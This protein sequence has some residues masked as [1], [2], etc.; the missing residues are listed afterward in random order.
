MPLKRLAALERKKLQEEY[1]ELVQRIAW[2]EDLLAH[3]EKVLG[4]IKEELLALKQQYNDPR[5]TQIVELG[6]SRASLTVQDM[7]ADEPVMVAL[8]ATAC[9]FHPK[10]WSNGGASCPTRWGRAPI[11]LTGRPTTVWLFSTDGRMAQFRCIC[12]TA[13][14]HPA[15]LVFQ[16]NDRLVSLLL[17]GKSDEEEEQYLVLA[18]T[19]A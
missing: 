18:T 2:L 9:S 1:A 5:R 17:L 12:P 6:V 19:R 10:W 3:P 16:R 13:T 8:A 7:M 14:I 11:R 4:V 15:D